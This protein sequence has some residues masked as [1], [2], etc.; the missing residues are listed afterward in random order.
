M[1]RSRSFVQFLWPSFIGLLVLNCT[2]KVEND[3]G[4]GGSS[5][6]G[7]VSSGGSANGGA[8]SVQGGA[9]TSGGTPTSWGGATSGGYAGASGAQG[10]VGAVGGV[11][12]AGS[13]GV[14][15]AGG[16]GV[17]ACEDCLLANCSAELEACL[18]DV[19]CFN[20]DPSSPGQYQDMVQCIDG[21][22]ETNGKATRADVVDCGIIVVNS[23][24][25]LWPPEEMAVTTTDL[26][27]CMATGQTNKP[28]NS[29]W[30]SGDRDVSTDPISQPWAAGSCAKTS[31]A[32]AL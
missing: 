31:C 12:E 17:D 22:R 23:A 25:D 5:N 1:Q 4:S 3:K 30:S 6:G 26:I 24:M 27:N 10:G 14:G 19:R 11:G 15:G 32:N 16:A 21:V 2:V 13:G 8:A 28:N 29:G 20:D 18:D 7:A 9:T